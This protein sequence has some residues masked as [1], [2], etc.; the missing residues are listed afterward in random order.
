MF[1]FEYDSGA[2]QLADDAHAVPTF[3]V[4]EL[5]D[6]VNSVLRRQFTDGVWVRGEIQ[7]WKESR[8]HTYFELVEESPTG[9]GV[10]NVQFFANAQQRLRPV[11]RKYRLQLGNGMKV[12]IFGH[13]DV[14][15]ATGRFGLKM[16]SIDPRFTLGELAMEREDV[17][18]RLVASGLF[19][20]NRKRVLS[21]A[22]IRLGVVASLGS[23]AWADFHSELQRSGVGFGLRV[24]DVRVQGDAAVEMV[25]AGIRTLGGCADL[26]AVVVIRGGGSK[27][28]LATFDSESIAM[29]IAQCRLPVLTGLGH[30]VDRSV[31]DEVAH[32]AYKTP[33]ACA[34]A[35]VDRVNDVV[36][37]SE[38][39]WAAISERATRAVEAADQRLGHLARTIAIRTT[40]AVERGE[41]RLHHRA[42]RV[43]AG[44][45]RVVDRADHRVLAAAASLARGPARL[46]V[47]FRHLTGLESQVRL[48]DPV[49][50]LARGWS[51]TRDAQGRAI[52]S[53][54]GLAHG[55]ILIT[56]FAT[57]VAESRV[58]RAT[59]SPVDGNE[60]T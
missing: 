24:V 25:T 34:A 3:S 14:Y 31:A 32:T 18:R 59:G 19:D 30:E 45:A 36:G 54:A 55:D 9:K 38:R 58:E 49:N 52:T 16:S 21:A 46:D 15:A 29:A 5:T 56:T 1:D 51:I 17:V 11:L 8:S 22:P 41:E 4:C 42:A 43:R 39:A 7:G 6:A 44:G 57:G 35:L 12:R 47:E 27:A 13:L 20:A 37:R 26:D 33:T 53:A 23:A 2:D 10:L 48:V 60:E 50:T 40:A 28:D